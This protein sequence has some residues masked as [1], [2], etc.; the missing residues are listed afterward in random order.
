MN[1]YENLSLL[2]NY[3]KDSKKEKIKLI[4]SVFGKIIEENQVEKI[5]YS[6]TEKINC[7]MLSDKYLLVKFLSGQ[8]IDYVFL[9]YELFFKI[10]KNI[11]ENQNKKIQDIIKDNLLIED[12]LKK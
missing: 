8:I 2:N 6:L 5:I 7:S 10:I 3:E 11:E 12:E 9:I 1:Y 4:D